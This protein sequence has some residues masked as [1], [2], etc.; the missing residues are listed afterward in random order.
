M[1]RF[2]PLHKGAVPLFPIVRATLED[3]EDI[4]TVQKLAFAAEARL[5]GKKSVQP[6]WQTLLSMQDDM[7]HQVV[8]KAMSGTRIVG[9]VRAKL[10]GETC[11]VAKLST[12][13]D[14]Q[15]RGIGTALLHA[16][17]NHFPEAARFELF[18]GE[19]SASNLRLYER[20]GYQR[21]FT[22]EFSPSLSFV[23]MRKTRQP[24]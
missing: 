17:E 5:Y 19:K 12:H 14:F 16:I 18:T 8:L 10:C 15:R 24:L 6:L 4:L 7:L 3:S 20:L 22:R 21:L 11:E 23:H 9:S 13:P 2:L 1:S